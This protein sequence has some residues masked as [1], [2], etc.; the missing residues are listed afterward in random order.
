MFLEFKQKEIEGDC[1]LSRIRN[2]LEHYPESTSG[3]VR[4]KFML[5]HEEIK[6]LYKSSTKVL[7][8]SETLINI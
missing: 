2:W 8:K 4:I 1:L 3:R 6:N 7:G 5:E